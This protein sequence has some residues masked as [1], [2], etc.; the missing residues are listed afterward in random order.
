[1]PRDRSVAALGKNAFVLAE[2]LLARSVSGWEWARAGAVLTAGLVLGQLLRLLLARRVGCN[3]SE[4]RAAV[5]V[6]RAAG[7]L[8]A[9]GAFVYALGILGVRL[10]PLLGAIGIGGIAVALAAQSIL[11]NLIGSV[12]LQIRR[13]FR[14]GDQ[15]GSCDQEGRVEE[16]NFR[17]VVLRSYDGQRVFLP[18]SKVVEAPIENYTALGRR[19]SCLEVG[20]AYGTDLRTAQRVI[21]EAAASVTGVHHS[22]SAEALVAGFGESSIE[23]D[24]LFWHA[25]DMLA[26]R[27]VRSAVAI[28]VSEALDE[29]GITIPFPQRVLHFFDGNGAAADLRER[30]NRS[31]NGDGEEGPR[32]DGRDSRSFRH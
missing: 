30:A 6:G 14:R 22:P 13:P 11:A 20:V 25:P 23:F 15:I 12:I 9:V 4:P 29:A 18:S 5:V 2:E 19:R 27:R 16:I 32:G 26:T 21:T 10:G 24:V 3:D 17:T 8:V 7:T 28:A 1:V 31:G